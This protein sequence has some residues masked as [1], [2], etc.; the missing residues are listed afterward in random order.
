M[1]LNDVSAICGEEI[2]HFLV[3]DFSTAPHLLFYAYIPIT[4]VSVLLSLFILYKDKGSLRSKLLFGISLTFSLWI[5]NI[6]VQWIASYHTILLFA[7][8]LT[9]LFEVLFYILCLYFFLVFVGKKDIAWYT[10]WVLALPFVIVA[11]L[12]PTELNV[13]LYDAYNCEGVVGQL[14]NLLYYVIEPLIILAIVVYGIIQTL[15]TTDTRARGQLLLTTIGL[16][17]FLF[18]F[19]LSNVAAELTKAYEINLIGP[20]GMVV[21]L[22]LLTY[23]M[24][25]FNAF[26]IKLLGAQ[27][28]MVSL[29]VLLGSLLFVAQS[30]TTRIIAGFTLFA[31]VSLGFMLIRS[32]KQ[33]FKQKEEIEKLAQNLQKANEQLKILDKMKSE[34]VSIASHQLRSPLTAIRGYTSMLLEG[35]FGKLNAKAIEAIERIADSSRFMALSVEDYLNVSRIE[36]GNMKYEMADFNLKTEAERIVD[37]LRPTALKKGLLLTFKSDCDSDAFIHADIGKT[38][39][40]LQNLIDNSMKYTP[41]GTITVFA[42]DDIKK[43]RMYITITDTGVGMSKQTIEDV[44]EKF[45]RAKNANHVNVTGTGLGLFVAKK[46]VE[47][48]GGKIKATSEGEGKGSS[49]VIEWKLVGNSVRG[50]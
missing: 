43:K 21:F 3:F 6:L 14:W 35:S 48:M 27:A 30:S 50:S 1:T 20:L 7:W 16:S 36:A 19:W 24:V 26:G 37:E 42:Y 39:Q 2:P 40:V 8:E 10:K 11:I 46:M 4:V 25:K 28:L 9:A 15:A 45:V 22:F 23:Q 44:F 33:T 34:F 49:F 5:L 13:A 41:K 18:I 38:R 31:A 47:E 12:T 29:W 32:I 17:V